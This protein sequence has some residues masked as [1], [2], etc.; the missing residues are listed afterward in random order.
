MPTLHHSGLDGSDE[1]AM[2]ATA[3]ILGS[4]FV[5]LSQTRSIVQRP[6]RR[7]YSVTA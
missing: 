5:I 4:D 2:I 6:Q 1:S 3:C 7:S